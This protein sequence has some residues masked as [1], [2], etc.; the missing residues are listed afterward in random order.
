MLCDGWGAD[1][2]CCYRPSQIIQRL[3]GGEDSPGPSPC[4][5]PLGESLRHT[6]GTETDCP[7]SDLAQE[8]S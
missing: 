5:P 4:V 8:S 6:A 1:S 2:S 7:Q 3:P